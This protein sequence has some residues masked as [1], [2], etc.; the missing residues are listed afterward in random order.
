MTSAGIDRDRQS[1][2]T[3]LLPEDR[4]DTDRMKRLGLLAIAAAFVLSFGAS[5]L[6]SGVAAAAAARPHLPGYLALAGFAALAAGLAIDWFGNGHC[7]RCD[8]FAARGSV[9]C[10]SHRRKLARTRQFAAAQERRFGSSW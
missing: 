1:R 9:F 10:V 4:M 8:R 3:A 2:D 5:W 7:R 6:P